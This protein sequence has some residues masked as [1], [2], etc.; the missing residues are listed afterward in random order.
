MQSSQRWLRWQALGLIIEDVLTWARLLPLGPQ[1][2]LVL[3]F[4]R[5]ARNSAMQCICTVVSYLQFKLWDS[6]G[7]CQLTTFDVDSSFISCTVHNTIASRYL[8]DMFDIH[9]SYCIGLCIKPMRPIASHY[10]RHIALRCTMMLYELARQVQ[11]RIEAH[12]ISFA[13][14]IVVFKFL[15]HPVLSIASV[16]IHLSMFF[17][18]FVP[19]WPIATVFTVGQC[20]ATSERTSSESMTVTRPY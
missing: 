10:T 15:P 13:I 5:V 6:F 9:N 11:F 19:D 20:L 8:P 14:S 18:V 1:V 12:S 17:L 4:L 2:A 3:F 16:P 7:W